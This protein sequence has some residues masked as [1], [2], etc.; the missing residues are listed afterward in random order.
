MK[1]YNFIFLFLIFI[2]IF[3]YAGD[4]IAEVDQLDCNG[5]YVDALNLLL[6]NKNKKDLKI[7]WR[8]GRETFE[9]ANTKSKKEEKLQMY[10]IGINNTRPYINLDNGNKKDRAE[11]IHWYAANYASKIKILGIFG[12]RE[13]LTIVPR[14]FKLMDMCLALDPTYVGAYFFTAKLQEDVPFFLGGDKVQMGINYKKA[15]YF[16]EGKENLVILVDAAKG[17]LNRDWTVDKTKKEAHKANIEWNDNQENLSD[18][19]YARRLLLKVQRVYDKRVNVSK[20]EEMKYKEALQ[21]IKKIEK[22][23]K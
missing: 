21:I 14:I 15:I 13:S 11:I 8:I 6:K 1:R 17:F 19:S 4:I 16:S 9:I 20:R 2:T 12:G 10:E 3:C 22:K 7:I 5:K 18:R 23:K